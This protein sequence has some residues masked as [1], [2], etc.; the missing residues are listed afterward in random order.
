MKEMLNYV[1]LGD[2]DG[3]KGLFDDTDSINLGQM[4]GTGNQVCNDAVFSVLFEE[5][6][7]DMVVAIKLRHTQK[8]VDF[9]VHFREAFYQKHIGKY[10]D[11]AQTLKKVVRALTKALDN[12]CWKTVSGHG[13]GG[14]CH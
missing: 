1:M 5:P 11:G 12:V 4:L 9:S 2:K 14:G 13:C 10:M 3:E 6:H 8:R 7:E